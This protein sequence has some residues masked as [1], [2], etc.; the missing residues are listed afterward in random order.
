[1]TAP[2]TYDPA[3][4]VQP[5]KPHDA[6]AIKTGSQR[7]RRFT[8]TFWDTY[9]HP[10]FPNGR[11]FTGEREFASGAS[12]ESI[13]AG[14]VTTDLQR[15]E[16]F[17]ENPE[18]G[19]TP[20]ERAQTLSS[21]WESPWLPLSKYWRFN[22]RMKRITFALDAMISDERAGLARYWEAAAKLAGENDVID[23]EHPKKV[24]F[25]IRTLIGDPMSYYG[26]MTLARAAQA[27]N[28]WLM[29]AA[30]EPDEELA[31]ILGINVHYLGPKAERFGDR[32]YVAGPAVIAQ[33]P[34][35]EPEKVVAMPTDQLMALIKSLSDKVDAL[36]EKKEKQK[37]SMAKARSA[38]KPRPVTA[39]GDV[40]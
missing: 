6:G 17:C 16:Y 13:A 20:I 34:L 36:T 26:K 4:L 29:G 37:A 19:Q 12:T 39:V 11:P 40:G 18:L 21:V 23:P 35:I 5:S 8:D 7:D 30:P 31:K 22:Y 32:E 3:Y 2:P 14:F 33:Q 25:R 38:R 10:R 28:P 27:G 1:M 24:P 15:G 9:R